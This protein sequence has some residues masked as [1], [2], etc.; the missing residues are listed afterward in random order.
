VSDTSKKAGLDPGVEP[1]IPSLSLKVKQGFMSR[2]FP[3]LQSGVLVG[4]QVGCSL[5]SFLRDQVGLGAEYLEK[6]IQT[7]FLDGKAV[8][9]AASAVVKDGSTIAL[10]A[11]MPGLLGATLRKGSF[12]ARLREQIS[13]TEKA[14]DP[15]FK[16]GKVLVKLF[17]LLIQEIGPLFLK[18]GIYMEGRDLQHLIEENS[19]ALLQGCTEAT[20]DG[21]KIEP[22]RLA[23]MQWPEGMVFLQIEGDWQVAEKHLVSRLLKN[24]QMQGTQNSEE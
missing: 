3:F 2:F 18:R 24:I 11:A 4:G 10:S 6:R 20:L 5:E 23:E 9:D 7:F 21:S 8:D 1:G 13:Y 17:N 12:Y 14:A 22:L 16:E 19:G 15:S